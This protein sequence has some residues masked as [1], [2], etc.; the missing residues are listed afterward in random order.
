M[1]FQSPSVNGSFTHGTSYHYE[2]DDDDIVGRGPQ[3]YAN[4][5]PTRQYQTPVLKEEASVDVSYSGGMGPVELEPSFSQD[6]SFHKEY[7]YRSPQIPM[8]RV[9]PVQKTVPKSVNNSMT[10]DSVPARNTP[11]SLLQKKLNRMEKEVEHLELQLQQERAKGQEIFKHEMDKRLR[12][13]GIDENKTSLMIQLS[14][15]TANIVRM[16]N[17]LEHKDKILLQSEAERRQAVSRAEELLQIDERNKQKIKRLELELSKYKTEKGSLG[18]NVDRLAQEKHTLQEYAEQTRKQKDSLAFEL[19]QLRAQ[20][21]QLRKENAVQR[22]ELESASAQQDAI[23]KTL[24]ITKSELAFN[25]NET[26]TAKKR[27]EAAQVQLQAKVAE[28][29]ELNGLQNELL[30][31]ISETKKQVRKLESEKQNNHGEFA[32]ISKEHERLEIIVASLQSDLK[33]ARSQLVEQ[34]TNLTETMEQREQEFETEREQLNSQITELNETKEQLEQNIVSLQNSLQSLHKQLENSNELEHHL[35]EKDAKI[36]QLSEQLNRYSHEVDNLNEQL[37]EY[38]QNKVAL[39][40][41]IQKII[42][43]DDQIVELENDLSSSRDRLSIIEKEFDSTKSEKIVERK[44]LHEEIHDLR[45]QRDTYKQTMEEALARKEE[46]ESNFEQISTALTEERQNSTETITELQQNADSLA[47]ELNHVTSER[48]RLEVELTMTKQTL[49]ET[50]ERL[51]DIMREKMQ[52]DSQFDH[53]KRSVVDLGTRTQQQENEIEE[54]NATIQKLKT[55][56][57]EL[58]D[59]STADKNRQQLEIQSLL[60]MLKV[61][62]LDSNQKKKQIQM[63]EKTPQRAD[64]E[65]QR[66]TIA[67]L[68]QEKEKSQTEIEACHKVIKILRSTNKKMEERFAQHQHVI[69]VLEKKVTEEKDARKALAEEVI[70]LRAKLKKESE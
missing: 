45:T 11:T 19:Q 26:E 63:L 46:L 9:T 5:V 17:D 10:S 13:L 60:E 7:E 59:S 22:K 55:Q 39:E 62:K 35:S 3:S 18:S 12:E 42:H 6:Q 57:Q 51:N 43:L 34:H 61:L 69:T 52:L 54:K 20:N 28:W 41:A 14:D 29:E 31:A 66:E 2:E 4:H 24:D 27:L 33:Q 1:S 67:K 37:A 48:S 40:E 56:L 38:D 47:T 30:T 58:I 70:R 68:E 64:I 44:V 15:K 8:Q 16:K 23:L 25:K 65:L 21:E 49:H 53:E 32:K 36:Q 50:S